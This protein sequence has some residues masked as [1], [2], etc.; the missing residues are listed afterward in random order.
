MNKLTP[1]ELDDVYPEVRSLILDRVAYNKESSNEL[2]FYSPNCDAILQC[3][4][5]HSHKPN[6]TGM[7]TLRNIKKGEEL[8]ENYYSIAEGE[9]HPV[10]LKHF[11]F[12]HK[13]TRKNR[14]SK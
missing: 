13:H 10:S 12:L 14:P 2:I 11:H 1:D 9:L 7:V 5:N 6:T 4:M 8:T 3:W